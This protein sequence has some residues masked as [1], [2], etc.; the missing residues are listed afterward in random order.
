MYPTVQSGF[1]FLM[2][3]YDLTEDKPQKKRKKKA[4]HHLSADISCP[5]GVRLRKH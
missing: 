3:W 1:E 2:N 4:L 5:S